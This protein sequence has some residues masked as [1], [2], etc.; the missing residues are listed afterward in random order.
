MHIKAR[1]WFNQDVDI[2]YSSHKGMLGAIEKLAFRLQSSSVKVSRLALN[3]SLIDEA[4]WRDHDPSI[5]TP[6]AGVAENSEKPAIRDLID[7][8]FVVPSRLWPSFHGDRV[9][10]FRPSVPHGFRGRDD[11]AYRMCRHE[12]ETM[13]TQ[14][15]STPINFANRPDFHYVHF[16]PYVSGNQDQ[17]YDSIDLRDLGFHLEPELLKHYSYVISEVKDSEVGLFG[18]KD[19]VEK[20]KQ[21]ILNWERSRIA[22]R[23]AI[24]T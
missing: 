11:W 20:T 18:T 8:Y 10:T 6:L 22:A 15:Y 19:D 3:L 24:A 5:L 1:F 2:L 16:A 4:V 7:V 23:D 13:T 17:V 21:G 14:F 12:T 9:V